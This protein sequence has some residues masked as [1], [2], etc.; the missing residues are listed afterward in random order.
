MLPPFQ[1]R[2]NRPIGGRREPTS[3]GA[4]AAARQSFKTRRSRGAL[5]YLFIIW[6]EA[7]R[8]RETRDDR[9][10]ASEAAAHAADRWSGD[11]RAARSTFRSDLFAPLREPAE[12]RYLLLYCSKTNQRKSDRATGKPCY[13]TG[14]V[15]S[16]LLTL[17]LATTI[18]TETLQREQNGPA[19]RALRHLPLRNPPKIE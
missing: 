9:C 8:T 3:S 18:A 19:R 15:L 6:V 14:N 11:R 17:T 4:A 13:R 5:T 10:G 12:S 7:L 2:T 16:T 1:R